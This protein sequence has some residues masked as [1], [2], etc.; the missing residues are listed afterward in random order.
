VF[1]TTGVFA[2]ITVLSAGVLMVGIAVDRLERRLLQWKPERSDT[3]AE[4]GA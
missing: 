4:R 2:G 1:D 3:A